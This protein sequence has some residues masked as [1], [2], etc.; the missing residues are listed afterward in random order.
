MG[1]RS[2]E[3]SLLSPVVVAVTAIFEEHLSALGGSLRAIAADKVGVVTDRTRA[4]VSAVQSAEVSSVMSRHIGGTEASY[5]IV[6]PGSQAVPP[7]S[8][9]GGLNGAAADVGVAAAAA[10]LDVLHVEQPSPARLRRLSDVK[11]PGR[12]STHLHAGGSQTIVC[13]CAINRA[14]AA[15]ARAWVRADAG[16]DPDHVVFSIPDGKDRRGVLSEI[17]DL[18]ITE[19]D[20]GREHLSYSASDEPPVAF[21]ALPWGDLGDLVLCIGTVSFVGRVLDLVD[22]DTEVLY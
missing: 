17:A 14:G 1:G 11:L 9:P 7:G 15:A 16:T 18:D 12:L 5:T 2:D 19:V 20:P 3:L 10:M 22:A 6:G 13:D 21:D 4:V 8:R